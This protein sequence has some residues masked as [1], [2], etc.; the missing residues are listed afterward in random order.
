MDKDWQYRVKDI[1]ITVVAVLLIFSSV[2]LALYLYAGVWPPL[3]IVES[4]SMQHSDERSQ[5]GIIDTGDLV[6]IQKCDVEELVSYVEGRQTGH[7]TFGDYG[8][9]VIYRPFGDQDKKP[10]IHRLV[11]Y[12]EPLSGDGGWWSAP[13]LE[14]YPSDLWHVD[15]GNASRMRGNLILYD[16]GYNAAELH[17]DLSSLEPHA[18]FISCGDNNNLDGLAYPDQVKWGPSAKA[19]IQEEWIIYKPVVEIPWVGSISLLLWGVN[20][21][22]IPLNSVIYTICVLAAVVI[23]PVTLDCLYSKIRP[24]KERSD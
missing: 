7:Y 12:L 24:P 15:E 1:I 8:D 10:I 2:L 17:L 11:L 19:L 22:M 16:Y 23:V 5:L 6:I 18:G 21:D 9:V 4:S 14:S 3:S 20:T 13:A